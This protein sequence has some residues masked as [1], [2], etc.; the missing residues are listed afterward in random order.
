VVEQALNTDEVVRAALALLDEG[1]LN[2]FTMRALARRLGTYPATIYWH[3]GNRTEVLSV[4]SALVLDQVIAELPDP[5]STP[6]DEWL[7]ETARAYRRAMQLHPALAAWGVTHFEARVSV[8]DF[9]ERVVSVL[10]RAGFRGPE[11]VGA[12]NAYVGSLIGWVGLELIADDPELG[13]DPER[14]EASVH[15]LSADAYPTVVANLEHLADRAIAFR[16][17]GGVSNP[18][19]DAFEFALATWIDGLRE[20]RRSREG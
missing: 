14:L 4:V 20:R 15:E 13:S 2:G 10:A 17:H 11:L 9:V 5:M 18:L 1:G 16:W 8:P 12:Y 7:I 19:D 3:V 6:W